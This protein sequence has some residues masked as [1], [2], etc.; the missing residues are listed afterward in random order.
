MSG[1]MCN[2]STYAYIRKQPEFVGK[3]KI[4]IVILPLS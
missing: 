1:K 3:Y 4:V 2:Y